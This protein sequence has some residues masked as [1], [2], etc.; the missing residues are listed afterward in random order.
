MEGV[1][2]EVSRMG[3][4]LLATTEDL[5]AQLSPTAFVAAQSLLLEP[6]DAAAWS[7]MLPS[8]SGVVIQDMAMASTNKG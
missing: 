2:S 1:I 4:T 7:T 5:L 8:I 6:A 3:Q